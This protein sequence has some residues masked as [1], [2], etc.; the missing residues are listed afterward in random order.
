MGDPLG[1]F[2][3]E[4]DE[5]T[6]EFI[7]Y[8]FKLETQRELAALALSIRGEADE[9]L[10]DLWEVLISSIIVTKSGGVSMARDLAHSRP[11]RVDTKVP[12]SAIK[13][14]EAQLRYVVKVFEEVRDL[15]KGRSVILRGDC[16]HLPLADETVDLIVTSPPYANAIDYMRAHKFS[17]V[18]LGSSVKPLGILRGRYV[19][20][21]KLADAGPEGVTLPSGVQ[22]AVGTL[23]AVDPRQAR[24][25]EKYFGDM[26]LAIQEMRRV[27]RRGRAV[28][29]VIGPSTM[30]GLKIETHNHLAAI[31]KEAGFELI[32]VAQRPIN[33]NRR[34]LPASHHH[35]GDSPI[36]RRT[37]LEYVIGLGKP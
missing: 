30:R 26:S 16:R 36:E 12:R 27:V 15:P 20:S 8:W 9:H 34:M 32:K 23:G 35:N 11:H 33:R 6:R 21:E 5:A 29:I 13:M 4:V 18:W 22:D 10:R 19:G 25:L 3:E 14:F 7:D 1:Q 2:L 31:A 37:H 17:L 24:I 28:I